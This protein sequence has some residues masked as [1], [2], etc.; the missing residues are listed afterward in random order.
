VSGADRFAV[1]YP[2]TGEVIGS[3]RRLSRAEVGRVLDRAATRRFDLSRYERSHILHRIAD[4]LAA[5]ADD[6]VTLITL[7]SGM[8]LQDTR[9]EMRRA[10]DVFRFA[11]MEALRDDGQVFA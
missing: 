4:L 3:A 9:Y 1:H 7:E 11:A 5:E 10:Q 2:C 6:F 8:A